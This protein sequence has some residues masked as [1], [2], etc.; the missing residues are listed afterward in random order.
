MIEDDYTNL[1]AGL[2]GTDAAH[3]GAVLLWLG[4][5]AI[6]GGLVKPYLRAAIGTTRKGLAGLRHKAAQT[7]TRADDIFVAVIAAVFDALVWVIDGVFWV[8]AV[9][10]EIAPHF[11]EATKRAREAKLLESR[12]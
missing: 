3:I 12:R 8:L 9:V 1:V 5:A 11:E 10:V 7:S 4:S 2:L 6:V